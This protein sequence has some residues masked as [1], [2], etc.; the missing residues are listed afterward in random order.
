MTYLLYYNFYFQLDR[1]A[2][3]P[4]VGAQMTKEGPLDS[5]NQKVKGIYVTF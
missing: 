2:S 3:T 1:E 5:G 4:N